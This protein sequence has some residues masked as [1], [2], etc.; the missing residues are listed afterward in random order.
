MSVDIVFSFDTTGSMYPAVAE[1]RRRVESTIKTLFDKIP[2]L[3]I[4]LI[5]HGDYG[6]SPYQTRYVPLTDNQDKLCAFVCNV[7]TTNGFGNGGECYELVMQQVALFDWRADNRAYVLIGD[8]PAHEAGMSTYAPG[9]G[10]DFR[11]T[12]DWRIELQKLINQNVTTYVVRCLNRLDSRNFHNELSKRSGTPLLSLAQFA[13]IEKIFTALVYKQHSDTL[14]HE[15]GEELQFSGVLN[16]NISAL[17]NDI[18]GL[19]AFGSHLTATTDLQLVD[20]SR[21]QVLH[22]DRSVDI[23][24]FVRS[25]GANFKKGRGFYQLTKRE[26]IQERK[27]VILQDK[28]TGDF[29][30]GAKAREMIGLPFGSRGIVDSHAAPSGYNVFVQSTSVNRKLKSNTEF[31]YDTQ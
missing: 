30:T 12:I 4:G 27:E 13:D 6:D 21:F 18:L 3:R 25:A 22:V 1:M 19:S 10:Y 26:L 9:Y 31:L 5:A 20:P 14:V 8:E 17:L 23:Q 16:R 7:E 29:Y 24:S 15:Y 28:L 2:D 11:V